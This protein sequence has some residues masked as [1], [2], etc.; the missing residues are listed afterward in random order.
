[1]PKS[2]IRIAEE[3]TKTP[4]PRNQAEGDFSGEAFLEKIL[5]PRFLVA[6]SK[7]DQL[8]VVLDGTEGYATS[9]LEAAFGGL[10][11]KHDPN[12]V[13]RILTFES[14]EEPFLVDEIQEYIREARAK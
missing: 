12:V 13:L 2:I 11:R 1:V 7:G 14:V 9:F 10:A 4:G 5:E 8:L 3:F 6:R